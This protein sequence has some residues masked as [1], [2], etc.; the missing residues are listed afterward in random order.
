MYSLNFYDFL[1]IVN[2]RFIGF[3]QSSIAEG[4][5]LMEYKPKIS[6]K[7][8][9]YSRVQGLYSETLQDGMHARSYLMLRMGLTYKTI[10]FG[11]G[12]NFDRYGP[13]KE[14]KENYGVFAATTLFN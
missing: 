12:A 11:A 3:S 10:T 5:V 13:F 1:L 8:S 14:S 2:P 9:I 6:E 4:L 7:W